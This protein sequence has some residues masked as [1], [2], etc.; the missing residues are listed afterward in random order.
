MPLQEVSCCFIP[1]AKHAHASATRG[2]ADTSLSCLG[3]AINLERLVFH[4][5]PLTLTG[6]GLAHLRHRRH[7]NVR[8]VGDILCLCTAGQLAGSR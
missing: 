7:I 6:K 2:G 3:S 8:F 5:I 1:Q 4:G